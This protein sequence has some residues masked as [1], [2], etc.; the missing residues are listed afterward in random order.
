[1][2][3]EDKHK[4]IGEEIELEVLKVRKK[5]GLP[6]HKGRKRDKQDR[7]EETAGGRNNDRKE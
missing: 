2:C 5:K 4:T 6:S 3:W 1:M 7:K